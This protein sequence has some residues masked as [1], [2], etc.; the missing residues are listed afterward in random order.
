MKALFLFI[1]IFVSQVNIFFSCLK[2][3]GNQGRSKPVKAYN[4]TKPHLFLKQKQ[5]KKKPK[6]AIIPNNIILKYPKTAKIVCISDS[7]EPFL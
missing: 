7:P 4:V 5:T 1:A 6:K 2:K 3:I